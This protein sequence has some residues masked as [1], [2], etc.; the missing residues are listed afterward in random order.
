MN[1]RCNDFG[2]YSCGMSDLY[3]DR[4]H[5]VAV[6]KRIPDIRASFIEGGNDSTPNIEDDCAIFMLHR[7]KSVHCVH[8]L[9]PLNS[10]SAD[11]S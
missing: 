1:I 7:P 10:I 9:S 4:F 2:S 11:W 3:D 5:T 6:L 8:G